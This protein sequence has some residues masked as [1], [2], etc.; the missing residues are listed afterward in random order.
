[1]AP[2]FPFEQIFGRNLG[3]LASSTNATVLLGKIECLDVVL[4]TSST[5][6]CTAQPV[7]AVGS[8]NVTVVYNGQAS[9]TD[10]V[11]TR[12]CGQGRFGLQGQPCSGCPRVR[13]CERMC[14]RA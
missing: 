4:L 13:V 8:Y 6:N 11:V 14:G 3:S 5:L 1:M 2:P 10:V 12:L 9:N 7:G